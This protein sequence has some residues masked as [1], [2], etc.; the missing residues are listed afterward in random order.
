MAIEICQDQEKLKMYI[1]EPAIPFVEYSLH[2]YL[3]M[4]IRWIKIKYTLH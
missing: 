3:H 4:R 1:F 2:E